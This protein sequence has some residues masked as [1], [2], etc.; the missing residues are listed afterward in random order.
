M[1]EGLAWREAY[2]VR[3]FLQFN[4]AFEITYFNSFL[5]HCH[6]ELLMPRYRKSRCS[7]LWLRRV[8]QQAT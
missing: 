2:A 6:A 3:A 4:S 7:S 8:G 1:L 5:K